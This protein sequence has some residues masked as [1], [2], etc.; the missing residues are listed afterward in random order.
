MSKVMIF[1]APYP[2]ETNPTSASRLRPLRMR[3]AFKTLGYDVIDVSGTTPQRRQALKSLRKT[4]RS[5]LRPDFLY[6]ENSTQPNLFATSIK[7]GIAPTLD[8]RILRQA[9]R[10]NIPIGVFYRDIYWRF[11]QFA[12]KDLIGRISPLLHRLDMCGYQRNNAHLF[13]PSLKMAEVMGLD[14]SQSFSALPPAGDDD[15]VLTLPSQPGPLRLFYVGGI[16]GHYRLD[17]LIKAVVASHNIQMDLVTKELQ[18]Q[19]AIQADSNLQSENIHPHHLDSWQLAPLYAQSQVA[20]L[21]VE[22]TP[23]WEFAAPVKLFEYI[24]RGRPILAS[25]GTEAARIVSKYDAGWVVDY[26]D[27]A[28]ADI[29]RHL[30]DHPEEIVEKAAKAAVAAKENTWTTRARQVAQTLCLPGA[31]EYVGAKTGI[32]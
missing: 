25:A 18:W 20:V 12:S 21:L 8:Y 3:E 9:H 28:I 32:D 19:A 24:S 17:K 29:L 22:P 30:Q 7:D 27:E 14:A 16:G 6:S 15:S 26:E 10:H 31:A 11:P 23:Y 4:L 13:L 1:H 2:M 5:G